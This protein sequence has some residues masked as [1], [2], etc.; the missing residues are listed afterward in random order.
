MDA[1]TPEC[2]EWR[3]IIGGKSAGAVSG[4]R[5][6]VVCP[7]DGKVFAS[8]PASDAQDVDLAVWSSA[9]RRNWRRSNRAIPASRSG[10]A[11]RM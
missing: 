7:S 4:G 11:A 10:R 9:M 5:I 2:A 8:I 6:D 3:Q 1:S